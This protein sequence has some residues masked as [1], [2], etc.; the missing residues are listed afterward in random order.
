VVALK[1]T[2]LRGAVHEPMPS[3]ILGRMIVANMLGEELNQQWLIRKKSDFSIH[4]N[5]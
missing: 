5:L 3:F 2:T 4:A 1:Q